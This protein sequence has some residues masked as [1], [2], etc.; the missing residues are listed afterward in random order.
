VAGTDLSDSISREGER[1]STSATV[2]IWN[3]T[4][5]HVTHNR[6]DEQPQDLCNALFRTFD[7]IRVCPQQIQGHLQLFLNFMSKY[8]RADL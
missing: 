4:P 1:P 2:R 7:F 6:F 8:L 3:Y 5:K